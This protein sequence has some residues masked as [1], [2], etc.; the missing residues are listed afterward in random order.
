VERSRR[1]SVRIVDE[2]GRPILSE[3]TTK[4]EI[5]SSAAP[6]VLSLAVGLWA[7]DQTRAVWS[8]SRHLLSGI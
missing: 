6:A 8:I 2:E 5:D 4:A 1:L 3:K 7:A